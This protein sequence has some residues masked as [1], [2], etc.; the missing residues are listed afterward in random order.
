VI[1]GETRVLL[2]TSRDTGRWVIPKG[3]IDPG[4]S[5][6]KAAA[7]EAYE[8]AGVTGR[9]GASLPLGFYTYFKKLRLGES[10]SVSVEVYLLRFQK[11]FK[12]WPEKAQRKLWWTS[13]LEAARSVDEPGLAR[14]FLRLLEIQES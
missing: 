11:Q 9:I 13:P 7:L 5:P 1:G 2:L 8:E 6:A 4:L 3:N 12:K 14:L 10:Q